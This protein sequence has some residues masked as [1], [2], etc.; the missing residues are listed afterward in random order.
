MAKLPLYHQTARD[1]RGGIPGW[2]FGAPAIAFA[3][4]L[5]TPRFLPD[6]MRVPDALPDGTAAVM[7]WFVGLFL[8]VA[9]L[10]AWQLIHWARSR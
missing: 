5:V 1:G 8:G 2:W 10:S 9:L 6:V 4:A 7:R 3:Y